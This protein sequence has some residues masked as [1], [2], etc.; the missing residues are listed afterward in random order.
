MTATVALPCGHD[1]EVSHSMGERR[2]WCADCG[3]EHVVAAVRTSAITYEARP[4]H[5]EPEPETE[6]VDA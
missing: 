2:I 5:P 3:A 1:V 4:L 6:E